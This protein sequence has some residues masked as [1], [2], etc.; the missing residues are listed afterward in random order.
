MRHKFDVISLIPSAGERRVILFSK[1]RRASLTNMA[2]ALPIMLRPV[3]L[4]I[5]LPML[6]T[7]QPEEGVPTRTN[8]TVHV[9][10][11]LQVDG[12]NADTDDRTVSSSFD[13]LIGTRK[14]QKR[15]DAKEFSDKSITSYPQ[16]VKDSIVKRH[17]EL[18]ACVIPAASNMK[19]MTWDNELE[20]LADD[21]VQKCTFN[22]RPWEER[23]TESHKGVGENIWAGSGGNAD[24]VHAVTN[25][26]NETKDY[27]YSTMKCTPKKPCGHYTQVVWATTTKVGCSVRH[28]DKIEKI[29]W[30]NGGWVILCNYAPTGNWP[31]VHPYK[32]ADGYTLSPA[33]NVD[34][35]KKRFEVCKAESAG[36]TRASLSPLSW[37]VV[38]VVSTCLTSP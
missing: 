19:T 14:R 21:W 34:A 36:V 3:L 24:P 2:R 11:S 27:T 30:P 13:I 38:L 18:R 25:W 7:G 6:A 1:T 9:V 5:M 12:A 37:L 29:S 28:C 17:N 16:A 35:E 23:K 20:E 33:C 31:N 4:V 26:Y 8:H 10:T 32:K 15:S 22:H